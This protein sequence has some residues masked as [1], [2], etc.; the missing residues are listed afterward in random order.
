[1]KLLLQPGHRANIAEAA[2][3]AFPSECCGLM[4]G[5]VQDGQAE[6]LAIHPARNIAATPDRFEIAP[7]DHFAAL[8][9]ARAAGH[10]I[11]GCYH[12]HPGGAARPSAR[13]RQGAGEEDFLWLIAALSAPEANV[14]FA[15]FVYLG[16]DFCEIGLATGADLVTS[17]LNMRN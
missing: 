7:E 15:A 10:N 3:A 1:M 17:S 2:R 12:S 14:T 4:A 16:E 11:I 8:K 5:H 9:A 6:V 13:D